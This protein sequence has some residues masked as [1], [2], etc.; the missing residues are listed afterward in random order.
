MNEANEVSTSN[1]LDVGDQPLVTSRLSRD[2]R[3]ILA[4]YIANKC[5]WLDC[6]SDLT[7]IIKEP[8]REQG[9]KDFRG[10]KA[11]QRRVETAFD[12]LESSS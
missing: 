11:E 9:R 5:G 1:D 6:E 12:L 10:T 4:T 8:G 7:A 3:M 2:H